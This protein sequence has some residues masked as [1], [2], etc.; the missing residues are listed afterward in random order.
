M[1]GILPPANPINGITD[2]RTSASLYPLAIY[3][4]KLR[5]NSNTIKIFLMKFKVINSLPKAMI[6]PATNMV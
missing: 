1:N 2:N 4:N 3:I 6:K 5:K